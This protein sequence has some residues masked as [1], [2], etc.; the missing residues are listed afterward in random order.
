[1]GGVKRIILTV[2]NDL[3]YDQRMQ[4]ICR[5][6]ADGGYDVELV[7][8]K[9]SFSIPLNEEPFH[10]TR[11]NCW[12]DKGKM[13]YLEFNLRLFF[14]LMFSSFD[15]ACAIDLDTIAAVYLSG[16]L[17]GAKLAYDAHEYFT[18]V[19][20]VVRRPAIKKAW[21]CVERTFVPKF[22]LV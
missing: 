17:K 10:Q 14:Y 13:F 22:D 15:A 12:F 18:E 8:R 9:R 19:P 21:L 11:L 2:T 3:S 4:K 20:E 16:N 5:S 1:M 7:G 6:L